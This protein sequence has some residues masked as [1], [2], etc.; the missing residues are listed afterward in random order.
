MKQSEIFTQKNP[1]YKGKE[2][3]FDGMY[4]DDFAIIKKG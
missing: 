4:K 2:Q 3:F 1:E